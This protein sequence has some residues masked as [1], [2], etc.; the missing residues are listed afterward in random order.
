MPDNSARNTI[1]R[2]QQLANRV[3]P[4]WRDRTRAAVSRALKAWAQRIPWPSLRTTEDFLLS[5]NKL[6]VFPERVGVVL[7]ISDK[8][9]ARPLGTTGHW[10]KRS[11][12]V[13]NQDTGG[14]PQEWEDRGF[15]PFIAQPATD[16]TLQIS[17]GG[18]EAYE[19]RVTGYVRDAAASGTALELQER[20]E[21]LTMGGTEYTDT[22]LEFVQLISIEKEFGTDNWLK[23]RNPLNSQ[24][25]A[26]IPEGEATVQHRSVQ[27]IPVPPS[28]T[29]VRVE[30]YRKPEEIHTE[31]FPIDNSVDLEYLAW[32]AAGDIH[33]MLKEGQAANRAW[34]KAEE[35]VKNRVRQEK[36]S[37]SSVATRPA[38]TYM[39]LEL[40]IRRFTEL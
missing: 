8:T 22:T 37:P 30:Y 19:V 21:I 10:N 33:W 2:A 27:F 32:Q 39:N 18:S 29:E 12:G 6:L 24:I 14:T 38:F 16:T 11:A 28:G 20:F 31:D 9:N 7:N 17:A 1:T 23:A 40:P 5:G 36:V 26:F 34:D 25:I 13:Y 4:A 3:D 35:I 15:T